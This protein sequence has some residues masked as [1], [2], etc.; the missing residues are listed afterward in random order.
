MRIDFWIDFFIRILITNL[1][2][3][4]SLSRFNSLETSG[5][6]IRGR[7]FEAFTFK[8]FKREST[9]KREEMKKKKKHNN[10]EREKCIKFVFAKKSQKG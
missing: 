8:P 9:Q 10:G 3:F 1:L 5:V 2:P 7:D 4:I 6:G